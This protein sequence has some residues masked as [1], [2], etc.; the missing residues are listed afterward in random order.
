MTEYDTTPGAPIPVPEEPEQPEAGRESA[1][2]WS[3]VLRALD[4]LG[5][6]VSAWIN[7]VK[8]DPETR[9]RAREM[10]EKLEGYGRQ[11]GETFD[12]AARSDFARQVSSAAMA[13]GDVAVDTAR[14]VGDEAAKQVAGAV[15]SVSETIKQA[16]EERA[17]KQAEEGSATTVKVEAT[18]EPAPYTGEEPPAPAPHGAPDDYVP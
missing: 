14:K 16:A 5:T 9:R 15:R 10:Q 6:S 7:A 8:D 17:A 2:A 3:D 12:A 13:A 4:D 18:P 1:A 11:V